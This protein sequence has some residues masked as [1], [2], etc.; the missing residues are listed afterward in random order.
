MCGI[1]MKKTF[2]LLNLLLGVLYLLGI[3]VSFYV[4]IIDTLKGIDDYL[5]LFG[6]FILLIYLSFNFTQTFNSQ[7]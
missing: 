6:V 2:G 7:R 5:M 3:G 4:I 1:N